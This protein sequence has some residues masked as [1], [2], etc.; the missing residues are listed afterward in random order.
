MLIRTAYGRLSILLRSTTRFSPSRN[1][2]G[3]GYAQARRSQQPGSAGEGKVTSEAKITPNTPEDAEASTNEYSL[4]LGQ[5]ATKTPR[6]VKRRV[7]GPFGIKPETRREGYGYERDR[8][9]RSWT[10]RFDAL[11]RSRKTGRTITV[12]GLMSYGGLKTPTGAILA[13]WLKRSVNMRPAKWMT[14]AIKTSMIQPYR[15]L[16]LVQ[17]TMLCPSIRVS[18]QALDDCL[19][20]LAHFFSN[21]SPPDQKSLAAVRNLVIELAKACSHDKDFQINDKTVYW[22]LKNCTDAESLWFFE[23]LD[24]GL[25]TSNGNVWLRFLTRFID[26]G[27][28]ALALRVLD[29]VTASGIDLESYPVMRCCVKLLRMRTGKKEWYQIQSSILARLLELGV[30]PNLH[31]WTVMLYNAIEAKDY[32]TAWSMYDIGLQSGLEPNGVTLRTLLAL[33][34]GL[35]HTEDNRN[36][37][38]RV[39]NQA[40]KQGLVPTDQELT[41]QILYS[42]FIIHRKDYKVNVF[43]TMYRLYG[44]FYDCTPLQELRMTL[45]ERFCVEDFS[46]Q[47]ANANESYAERTSEQPTDLSAESWVPPV[48]PPPPAIVGIMIMGYL[49]QQRPPSEIV[50]LYDRYRALVVSNHPII[51]HIPKTPHVANAFINQLGCH[52]QTFHT[53]PA[54]IEHMR[55]PREEELPISKVVRNVDK[56]AG[57]PNAYTWSIYLHCA[58]R[59]REKAAAEQILEYMQKNHVQRTQVTWNTIIGSYASSQD[60]PATLAAIGEM[61][62]A[63]IETDDYTLKSLAR[64]RDRKALAKALGVQGIKGKF[65]AANRDKGSSGA[66]ALHDR[67]SAESSEA[68][69][70]TKNHGQR[71][72]HAYAQRR[73]E[74]IASQKTANINGMGTSSETIKAKW[75]TRTEA[76]FARGRREA[77]NSHRTTS[78]DGLADNLG[79]IKVGRESRAEAR[80]ARPLIRYSAVRAKPRCRVYKFPCSTTKKAKRC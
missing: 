11:D 31:L 44:R 60:G 17:A 25:L 70:D 78:N 52:K 7:S 71:L 77:A 24:R 65:P 54:I 45:P 20:Y 47:S 37:L 62:E 5:K 23:T 73:R 28:L 67:Y 63:K 14:F 50:D 41:F 39:V 36:N 33:V 72:D 34:R 76:R 53:I 79:D 22:I 61:R 15:A 74:A 29:K 8:L 9:S 40:E 30:R 56:D 42:A 1:V 3:R 55:E 10:P 27:N 21:Q 48:V 43:D 6:R 51:S 2:G 64:L 32:S 19:Y 69:L 75:Q 12:R 80:P 59:C 46:T 49:V 68:E 35:S 18:N 26:Q 13:A 58:V 4:R 16:R 57:L 66:T 38:G